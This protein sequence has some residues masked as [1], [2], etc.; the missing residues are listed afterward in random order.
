[1]WRRHRRTSARSIRMV[2]LSECSSDRSCGL[3]DITPLTAAELDAITATIDVGET[4]GIGR[5]IGAKSKEIGIETVPQFKRVSPSFIRKQFSVVLER[6]LLELNGIAC[7]GF[8]P[9]IECAR[10]IGH[11]AVLS[12]CF[13]QRT[14][15]Y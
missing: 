7:Y 3:C 10:S 9:S 6:T 13:A 1:M 5:K 14:S 8:Q 12:H 15:E 11:V 4:W 2:P